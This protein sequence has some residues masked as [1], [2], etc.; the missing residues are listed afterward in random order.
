MSS[1]VPA[2]IPAFIDL[3]TSALPQGTL[4]WLG[5]VMPVN[6]PGPYTVE[7]IN[8]GVSLQITGV[9]F[10]EDAFAELGPN[11]KHEEHYN[12]TCCLCAWAGDQDYAQRTQDVYAAY[13]DLSSA[14]GTSPTLNIPANQ[15]TFRLAWTRQLSFTPC[16]D[17]FG[18]SSGVIEFEVSCQARVTSLS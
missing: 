3:A 11:Y 17:A 7:G 4:V 15:G 14:V 8:A 1:S 2:A 12:I 5:T 16:P 6:Q 13:K 9:S 10:D 18:R